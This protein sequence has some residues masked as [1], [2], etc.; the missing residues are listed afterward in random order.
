[1]DLGIFGSMGF[2]IFLLVLGT[3][4]ALIEFSEREKTRYQ[5]K[6]GY[7]SLGEVRGQYIVIG[8]IIIAGIVIL[9]L[10]FIF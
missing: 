6:K 3:I 7:E 5:L 1:M 10:S 8:G 2:G 4:F 9:T